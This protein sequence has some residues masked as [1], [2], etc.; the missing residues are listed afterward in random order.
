[1]TWRDD[2]SDYPWYRTIFGKETWTNAFRL[3]NH[4]MAHQPSAGILRGKIA[5]FSHRPGKPLVKGGKQVPA[6]ILTEQEIKA[7][8]LI[9]DTRIR[10]FLNEP[11]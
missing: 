2:G 7:R 3:G 8:E 9:Q 11:I 5:H 10:E 1:M 6:T 4:V